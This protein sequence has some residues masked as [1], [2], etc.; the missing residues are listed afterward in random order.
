MQDVEVNFSKELAGYT[1]EGY[2]VFKEGKIKSLS[3][4]PLTVE[5]LPDAWWCLV[6]VV[7][8]WNQTPSRKRRPYVVLQIGRYLFQSG[9]LF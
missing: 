8:E 5:K 9:W 4:A 6:S 2:E 3:F 1:R 7:V